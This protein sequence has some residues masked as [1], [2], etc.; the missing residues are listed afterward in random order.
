MAQV[1]GEI[2]AGSLDDGIDL[3]LEKIVLMSSV[4]TY[5]SAS[6]HRLEKTTRLV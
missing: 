3:V 5:G 2:E 1:V 4:A 6:T